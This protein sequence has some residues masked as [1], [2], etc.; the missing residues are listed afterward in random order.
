LILLELDVADDYNAVKNHLP[1]PTT[2]KLVILIAFLG[3]VIVIFRAM[4]I[5]RECHLVDGHADKVL[6]L[7]GSMKVCLVQ[8][9]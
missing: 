1:S 2:E 9:S 3:I 7:V 5:Q 8:F 6:P 4:S